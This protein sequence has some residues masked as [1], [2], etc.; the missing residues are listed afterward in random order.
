[1]PYDAHDEVNTP[2]DETV[3]WRY[4]DFTKFVSLL[5]RRALYFARADT[6]GDPWEGADATLSAQE[7]REALRAAAGEGAW[8]KLEPTVGKGIRVFRKYVWIS[9]WHMSEQGE[10][11]AMWQA[12]AAREAGI[13]VRTTVKRLKAAI[14]KA[15]DRVHIGRVRYL[16]YSHERIQSTKVFHRFLS[17]RQSFR[18]END[19]RA[20]LLLPN[21][22]AHNIQWKGPE[23][24]E[25]HPQG[26]Y[27]RADVSSL[28]EIAKVAPETSDWLKM[29]VASVVKRYGFDFPVCR[30]E[31]DDPA[32]F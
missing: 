32:I 30:S 21:S 11:A 24:D 29:L 12:Y 3:L 7:F 26:I 28:V 10:S 9:C 1:M 4:M 8:Q 13:A 20:L 17:K 5:D 22:E 18:H 15:T 27:I 2:P 14:A 23:T 19:V 31:M 6:L 16:D 25:R